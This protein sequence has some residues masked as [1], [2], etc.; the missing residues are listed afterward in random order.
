MAKFSSSLQVVRARFP[1]NHSP[2]SSLGWCGL[3][4]ERTREG[5]QTPVAPGLPTVRRC[6]WAWGRH[7]GPSSLRRQ[8]ARSS[9]GKGASGKVGAGSGACD[10]RRGSPATLVPACRIH[11]SPRPLRRTRILGV[12]TSP[13]PRNPRT[14]RPR[15]IPPSPEPAALCWV[16]WCASDP[17][18]EFPAPGAPAPRAAGR[19]LPPETARE[20]QVP[21]RPRV[22]RGSPRN[23]WRAGRCA[24]SPGRARQARRAAGRQARAG[25]AALKP[26]T[27]PGAGPAPLQMLPRAG[28]PPVRQCLP[29][30]PVR[31]RRP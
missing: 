13:R 17:L 3:R 18:A 6:S 21:R 24:R 11:M 29:G 26:G 5:G 25:V 20:P 7:G 28:R 14:M 1:P 31:R 2:S 16:S 19:P 22:T 4:W 15:A 27:P 12:E 8:A 9:P 10:G 23:S 30:R